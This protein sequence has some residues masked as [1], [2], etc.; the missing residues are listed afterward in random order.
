MVEGRRRSA[1]GF[2]NKLIYLVCW[3]RHHLR[4]PPRVRG[5]CFG[6]DGGSISSSRCRAGHAASSTWTPMLLSLVPSAKAVTG[7]GTCLADGVRKWYRSSSEAIFSSS[8]SAAILLAVI[9]ASDFWRCFNLHRRPFQRL[10]AAFCVDFEAS[11]AVPALESGGGS[12]VS[13]SSVGIEMDLIA[14]LILLVRSFLHLPGSYVLFF[15]FMR[16][17]VILCTPTAWNI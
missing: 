2:L 5:R 6:C 1:D 3:R 14:F 17:F 4:S 11:G 7:K 12:L 9:H 15:Y 10:E 13:C 16:T 8:T